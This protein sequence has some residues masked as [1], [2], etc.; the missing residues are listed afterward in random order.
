MNPDIDKYEKEAL[1]EIYRKLRSI[2]EFEMKVA[3]LT[4]AGKFHSGPH[5]YIGQEAVAVGSCQPLEEDDIIGSTH[6]GH[7]HLIAKGADMPKMMAEIAGKEA[8]LN[9]GRGGTMHMVD[10]SLGIFGAN[11]ILGAS[12]PHVAGGL[13]AAQL[14]GEDPVGLAFFGDGALN[15]GIIYETMNLASVWELPVIFVC[16]N[17]QYSVTLSADEAIAGD[18][19]ADRAAAMD[20]PCATVDGQDVF[21][22]FEEVNRAVREAR[23]DGGPQFITCETYRF[24]EHS[25]N[26]KSALGDREYRSSEEVERWR[27]RDPIEIF[28]EKVNN[29]NK[30]DEDLRHRIDRE[31]ESKIKAGVKLMMESELPPESQVY[32]HMYAEQDYPNFPAT[33]YR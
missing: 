12:V 3:E 26:T 24:R 19:I 16:E 9:G 6:R 5:L 14:N 32:E 22:V 15:E 17:N 1:V 20:I 7:G 11:G 10:F 13:F 2:R 30:F 28:L 25:F 23:N 29:I 31:I 21:A 8:G 27:D 33:T 4:E 18:Q